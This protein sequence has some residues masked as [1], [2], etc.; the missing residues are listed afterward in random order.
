MAVGLGAVVSGAQ[1]DGACAGDPE[2]DSGCGAQAASRSDHSARVAGRGSIECRA[3]AA[4]RYAAERD[5]PRLEALR[6]G[7]NQLRRDGDDAAARRVLEFV[8]TRE[9]Q[10]QHFDPANFLGL[11]EIRLEEKSVPAAVD[12]LKR[13]SMLSGEPFETL[14]AAASL[15]ARFGASSE[16]AMFYEERVKAAPWDGQAREHLA[17]LRYNAPDLTALA[18]GVYALYTVRSDAAVALRR[19]GG[20]TLGSGTGE[21]DLLASSS[22]FT[23]AA[24]NKPY[25]HRARVEAAS[26]LK[27][28]AAKI[29]LLLAAVAIDPK[30]PGP[31][32]DLFRTALDQRRYTLALSTMPLQNLG[33][34]PNFP[35]GERAPEWILGTFLQGT[36]LSAADRAVV[37]R[38]VGEAYQRLKEPAKAIYYYR[39]ALE[40]DRSPAQRTAVQPN[41]D[42]LRT[43]LKLRQANQ[44]R[45]PVVTRNLEQP[46]VVKP[47]LTQPGGPA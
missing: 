46:H 38:G 14:T 33:V 25:W 7:A 40:L 11:A 13:M 8:Y 35:E 12:L 3:R 31:R 20:A 6:D 16:A 28:P 27:D 24:V 42:T 15:L 30:P 18:K 45:R 32:F 23:E 29:R 22:P 34:E 44:E 17:E 41:I 37:A 2:F 43:E 1:R 39:L 4:A 21:L 9:L 19:A 47:R 36:D 26:S 10:A 5:G